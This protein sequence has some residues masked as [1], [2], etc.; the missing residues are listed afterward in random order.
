M[1]KIFY[2]LNADTLQATFWQES[3][4]NDKQTIKGRW[5]TYAG[6]RASK[7][8]T[9]IIF[10]NLPDFCEPQKTI[11]LNPNEP[12][13]EFVPKLNTKTNSGNYTRKA[14]FEYVKATELG[15][16]LTDENDKQT[17]A[18]LLDKAKQEF[19]KKQTE[20]MKTGVQNY[21]SGL[22]K[23]GLTKEALFELLQAQFESTENATTNEEGGKNEKI[24]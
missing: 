15:D 12:K 20:K 21:L 5:Q 9:R 22:S 7:N 13:G 18:E 3:N 24:L 6:E 19:D 8:N 23:L 2:E 11:T 14:H 10:S 17:F 16:Y 4:P 1:S